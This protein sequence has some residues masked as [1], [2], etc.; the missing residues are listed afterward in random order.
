MKKLSLLLATAFLLTA[1]ANNEADGDMHQHD[2]NAAGSDQLAEG[3]ID[4]ICNMV[5]GDDWTEFSVVDNDTTW[6]CS[7]PCKKSFDANPAK[8]TK[9]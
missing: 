3:P 8:Y 9:Q 4:P 6:F 7:V 1:C 2:M 5:K